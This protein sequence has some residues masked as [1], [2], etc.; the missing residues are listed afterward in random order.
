MPCHYHPEL[1][2]EYDAITRLTNEAL[3]N[4]RFEPKLPVLC[5][6]LAL[7]TA[8]DQA[9]PTFLSSHTASN[10]LAPSILHQ[11]TDKQEDMMRFGLG[12]TKITI[13]LLTLTN[14]EIGTLFSAPQS[15]PPLFS[16]STSIAW[17]ASRWLRVLSLAL[18]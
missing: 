5:G 13:Y 12:R 8:A 15:L 1:L 3:C 10:S 16:Y 4:I 7:R 11:P 9:L 17:H 18:G 14:K 2:A 6:C